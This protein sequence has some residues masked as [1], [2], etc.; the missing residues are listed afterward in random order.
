L[1]TVS[2]LSFRVKELGELKVLIEGQD[3]ER[4]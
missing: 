2:H 3:L 1:E 4:G